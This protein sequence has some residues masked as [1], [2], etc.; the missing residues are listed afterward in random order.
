MTIVL[1][2]RQ[3]STPPPHWKPGQPLPK[4]VP[5]RKVV[6]DMDAGKWHWAQQAR[7]ARKE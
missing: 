7:Y 2:L 4:S 5:A 1:T 3:T 6:V